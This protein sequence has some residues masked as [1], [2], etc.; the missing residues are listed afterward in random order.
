MLAQKYQLARFRETH[1]PRQ[2]PDNA[3]AEKCAHS[4]FRQAVH[5]RP[6]R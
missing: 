3:T 4:D 6:S 5:S 2:Q 1:E